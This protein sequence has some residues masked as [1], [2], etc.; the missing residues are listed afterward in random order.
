MWRDAWVAVDGALYYLLLFGWSIAGNR[1][2]LSCEIRERC[3]G[4]MA[5]A[6]PRSRSRNS[7]IELLRLLA[8]LMIVGYHYVRGAEIG[9]WGGG[10]GGLAIDFSEEVRVSIYF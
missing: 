7:A 6:V 9:E 3:E 1:W 8:M 2:L 10:L 5:V 4:E